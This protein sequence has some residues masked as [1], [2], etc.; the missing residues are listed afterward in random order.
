MFP[1]RRALSLPDTMVHG[2]SPLG[3]PPLAGPGLLS[4]LLGARVVAAGHQT[5]QGP[6]ILVSSCR[7][8]HGGNA[9]LPV[10]PQAVSL[11]SRQ[12]KRIILAMAIQRMCTHCSSFSQGMQTVDA[13]PCMR[14]GLV[15]LR[16]GAPHQLPGLPDAPKSLCRDN[17]RAFLA[18][19]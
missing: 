18:A 6:H 1:E 2:S 8:H 15:M 19:E 7:G 17:S 5:V 14:C 13:G 9:G 10:A 11:G 12:L 16:Q 3:S 4:A